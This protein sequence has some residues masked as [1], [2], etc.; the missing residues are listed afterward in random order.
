[1]HFH[2][3]TTFFVFILLWQ[4]CYT[5]QLAAHANAASAV[6]Y[7]RYCSPRNSVPFNSRNKVTKCVSMRWRAM[8]WKI[9]L[10]TS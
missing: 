4:L 7:G 9:M 6:G 2:A 5:V 10:A 3:A 8:S 1:M